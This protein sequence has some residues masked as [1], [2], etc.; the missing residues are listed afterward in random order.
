MRAR[1]EIRQVQNASSQ[2]SPC[3]RQEER[4]IRSRETLRSRD[5]GSDD[6]T[7]QN[8]KK[9]TGAQDSTEKNYGRTWGI[10]A[11]DEMSSPA[12]HHHPWSRDCLLS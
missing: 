3:G 7:T 11:L 12:S 4:E 1:G 6:A 2:A 9:T 5:R 8:L 10:P